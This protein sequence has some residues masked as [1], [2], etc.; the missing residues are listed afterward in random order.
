MKISTNYKATLEVTPEVALLLER[1]RKRFNPD[2]QWVK[3]VEECGELA[4]SV[5]QL[6][7]AIAKAQNGFALWSEVASEIADVQFM[8]A[9][10]EHNHPELKAQVSEAFSAKAER[11]QVR[12]NALEDL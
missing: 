7:V 3:L 10:L 8:I 12:L 1:A 6:V 11:F 5:C 2:G 9:Q 4:S